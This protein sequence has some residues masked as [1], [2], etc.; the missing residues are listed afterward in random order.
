MDT[1]LKPHQPR[2]L[3]PGPPL[4]VYVVRKERLRQRALLIGVSVLACLVALGLAVYRWNFAYTYFGPA[5]VWRFAQPFLTA[6]LMFAGFAGLQ[7]FLRRAEARHQVSTHPRGMLLRG[8]K[9]VIFIPWGSIEDIRFTIIRYGLPGWFWGD[10]SVLKLRTNDGARHRLTGALSDLHALI[11]QV[12]DMVFPRLMN[13]YR[14]NLSQGRPLEFGP[15][16][17]EPDGL[18]LGRQRIAWDQIIQ[19]EIIAGSLKVRYRENER[20]KTRRFAVGRIPNADLCRQLL[21]QIEVST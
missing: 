21:E 18:Q 11:K 17:L 12:K 13:A 4:A 14:Y 1:V 16:S 19:A 8:G 2:K 5:V 20:V 7:V 10:R 15:I 3:D 6:A 9:R